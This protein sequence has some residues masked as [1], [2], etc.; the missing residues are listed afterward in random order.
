MSFLAFRYV[1]VKGMTTHGRAVLEYRLCAD[2]YIDYVEQNSGVG[3]TGR[4]GV[5]CGKCRYE[6]A[7]NVKMRWWL[8]LLF[9]V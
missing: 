6:Q 5:L 3:A 2:L 9:R 1:Y 7:S 8:L 4:D